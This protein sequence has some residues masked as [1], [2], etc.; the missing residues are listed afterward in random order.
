MLFNSVDFILFFLPSAVVSFFLV[1]RFVGPRV[2]LFCLVIC[3]LAYYGYWNWTYIFL[4]LGSALGNFS[5]GKILQH[6][7][8]NKDR[9]M[10]AALGIITNLMVLGY[11]K[12][13]NFTAENLNQIFG[14]AWQIEKIILPIG[15]SFFTFQQIAYLVDSYKNQVHS[16]NFLSYVLF[17]SFFPQLIA[18]PIVHH[19]EMLPQFLRKE[20]FEPKLSNIL[21]GFSIFSFGLFKKVILADNLAKIVAPVFLRAEAE[22][23]PDFIDAWVATT[24]FSLQI[25]FDF[26]GYSDMAIGLA[27]IFGIRLP[28]NFFSPYKATGI[29]EFWRRWHITL[30]RFLREYLYIPLGG[31]RDGK[32]RK[33][34][35]I[36]VTMLLGGL[37][38]GAGWNFVIWGGLHGIFLCINHVWRDAIP[39]RIQRSLPVSFG[40]ILT[41]FAV[42]IAWVFFR[43]E[44]FHGAINII[45]GLFNFSY[46]ET[47]HIDTLNNIRYGLH[48]I[49][50]IVFSDSRIV[51]ITE[52][53]SFVYTLPNLYS[54]Q[55][56]PWLIIPILMVLHLPN[57]QEIFSLFSGVNFNRSEPSDSVISWRPDKAWAIITGIVFVSSLYFLNQPTEFIY[58]Q[59]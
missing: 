8:R 30:S 15:L 31:N 6:S 19:K 45:K 57:T 3:S 2:G 58:F 1:A 51:Y 43:A 17:V 52:F 29:I 5:L 35:N 40:H 21:I 20:T 22:L 38:H 25:Y 27:L 39:N 34:F 54:A 37:W 28:L 9:W 41:L 12:Y 24:A 13:L 33:Y 4:I 55:D 53:T 18:G 44:T 23:I 48:L 7:T 16:N 36:G 10:L 26:S 42:A 59:F 11:F 50:E 14:L 47:N 49:W 56:L 32:I 46:L